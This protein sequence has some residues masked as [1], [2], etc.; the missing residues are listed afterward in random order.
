MQYM[1]ND[2]IYHTNFRCSVEQQAAV[3][4]NMILINNAVGLRQCYYNQSPSECILYNDRI[5]NMFPTPD[6][7]NIVFT[8]FIE[9]IYVFI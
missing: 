8:F 1:Q 3:E 9:H 4:H 6:N 2:Y 7:L 5:R